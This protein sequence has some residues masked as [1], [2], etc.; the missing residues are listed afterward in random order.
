MCVLY[1]FVVTVARYVSVIACVVSRMSQVGDPSSNSNSNNHVTE[2]LN[3]DWKINFNTQT[4]RGSV[5]LFLK[6]VC[7]SDLNPNILLDTKNLNILSVHINSQPAKW[8]LSPTSSQI[9]GSSLEIVPNTS[10]NS[11]DVKIDYETSPN[12][13]ALQWLTPQLT[14]DRRQPFMFSQCQAIHARSLLPCQDTPVVKCP[15]E[16]KV[17]AP[18]ETVVI[19]GAKRISEPKATDD[20]HITY[21]FQQNVP[22]PS[23]LI[24]IAC[25]DLAC[26]KIGPRSSVWAEP[27][28]VD[29]AA[30]EFSE[31]EQMISAAENICG[32]YQWGLYDI[33]VLPPTFPYGG[34]ENPCLTFVS[35]TILAGDRSLANVIAHEIAHSWT[36]NLVTNS[37]WEHFWLNEGHT[38]YLE[39]LII[40]SLYGSH[41][42]HLH[43]SLGYSELKEEINRLGELHP[44]TKLVTNLEGVDPDESY[45]RIPYEKG[46]L[47][48]Y[49][50]E[51]LYGKEKMLNW[52]KSYVKQ[53][54]G[55][56]LNSDS[57]LKFFSSQ[58]DSKLLDPNN[59]IH[60][61][62]HSPGLPTWVP[63]FDAD[64]LF[65]ECDNLLKL[66]TAHDL[67]SDNTK[68]QSLTNLWNK[69]SHI[70]RELTL[71][72][73]VEAEPVEINNLC[74][75]DEV[76][77]LS[78]QQNA[79]IRSQWCLICIRSR[80]LP[81]LDHIFEFLNSQGRMR[82]TRAIYRALVK[83]PEAKERTI[84]NFRQQRPFMHQTTAMQ[85]EIDLG[86]QEKGT[87]ACTT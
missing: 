61:W 82:Y 5:N 83:W 21:H 27:S 87:A 60:V 1:K 58:I 74:K 53:F 54:S 51:T 19:M 4:I 49:Y 85:V 56:S 63:K 9:F 28:I 36:G 10:T 33:L 47:L 72:N 17:T 43:L 75:I 12:S 41:M 39:R 25:G 13:S 77:K 55:S 14:A 80:H 20:G 45:N 67:H 11:F 69:L 86:L 23:Y 73:V 29:K 15:F 34:M 3:I 6:K 66:F 26:R 84:S 79:E 59:E 65:A 48:L 44:F 40:E 42:R 81:S 30:Y 32:P 8:H 7:S 78:K 70:Q 57:W 16:A 24:A 31:T 71:R 62:M 46:C 52:L 50:L 37:T 2:K 68:I 64:D 22:V 38:M 18:K 76:L 35:P